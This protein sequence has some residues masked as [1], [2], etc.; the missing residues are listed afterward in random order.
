MAD[1]QY[2]S[3]S[4]AKALANLR[5]TAL[6]NATLHL[7][8]EDISPSINTT[9]A[10]FVAAEADYDAYAA[11]AIAAWAEPSLA[12]IAGYNVVGPLQ[13]FQLAATPAVPNMIFGWFLVLADGTTLI[14]YG[15]FDPPRPLQMI[16]QAVSILPSEFFPAGV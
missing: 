3:M 11:K 14:D 5:Q 8:K 1:F 7:L 9:L 15:T 2:Q 12:S 4:G 10:E 6:A 13:T 16:D